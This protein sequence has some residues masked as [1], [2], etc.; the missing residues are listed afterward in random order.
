ML[1]FLRI[2]VLHT[3]FVRSSVVRHQYHYEFISAQQMALGFQNCTPQLLLGFQWSTTNVIELVG[4]FLTFSDSDSNVCI[5]FSVCIFWR[6]FPGFSIWDSNFCTSPNWFC[7]GSRTGGS[8]R[9]M[10]VCFRVSMLRD[11]EQCSLGFKWYAT[12]F[13]GISMVPQKR[14]P[15]SVVRHEFHEEFSGTPQ[16]Y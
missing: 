9:G 2:Q 11:S 10:L 6:V 7:P 13:I 3:A 1:V 5:L 15:I 14:F 4:M 8:V 12:K 16:M